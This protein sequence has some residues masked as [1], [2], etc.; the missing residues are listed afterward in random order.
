MAGE[1][2]SNHASPSVA[3]P[4]LGDPEKDV[5]ALAGKLENACDDG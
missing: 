3:E 5:V 4:I 2:A 1:M